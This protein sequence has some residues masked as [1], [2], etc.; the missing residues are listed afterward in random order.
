[1]A[2]FDISGVKYSVSATMELVSYIIFT[3]KQNGFSVS[4]RLSNNLFPFLS[5]TFDET[6]VIDLDCIY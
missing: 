4:L 2:G 5:G 1:M 3:L 6:K